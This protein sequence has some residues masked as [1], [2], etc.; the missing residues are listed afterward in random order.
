METF[1]FYLFKSTLCLATL[2]FVF[3][4]CFRNDTL[5][6]TNRL[7]LLGGYIVLSLVAFHTVQR[8]TNQPMA[9]ACDG[10]RNVTDK[11]SFGDSFSKRSY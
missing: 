10:G 4:L 2:Y 8:S 5:F 11:K 9:E 7:L 3:R 6:R 1:L